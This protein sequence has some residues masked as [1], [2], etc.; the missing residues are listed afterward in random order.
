MGVKL[1]CTIKITGESG[2]DN[3]GIDVD[4][5]PEVQDGGAWDDSGAG[6]FVTE[7]LDH[8]KRITG[9]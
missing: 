5:D 2:S 7:I 8:I 3:I 6:R 9:R 4:F 1:E